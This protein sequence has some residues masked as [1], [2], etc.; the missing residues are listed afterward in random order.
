[1]RVRNY[2]LLPNM[3]STI[4]EIFTRIKK[5]TA[6]LMPHRGIKIVPV[7]NVPTAAP[8]RSAARQPA[9]GLFSSPIISAATGNWNP[10]KNEKRKQ[11]ERKYNG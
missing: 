6:N 4:L 2:I 7:A 3:K 8:H 11:N 9:A 5:T 10:H 1:M